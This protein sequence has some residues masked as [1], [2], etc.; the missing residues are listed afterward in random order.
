MLWVSA[1]NGGMALA[2]SRPERLHPCHIETPMID[3]D[4]RDQVQAAPATRPQSTALTV[5]AGEGPSSAPRSFAVPRADPSFVTQLIAT[6]AHVPQTC[7]LRRASPEDA[8]SSYRA[9]LDSA[10]A[11]AASASHD[12]M[13]RVV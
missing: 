7:Q 11:R 13:S 4:T 5:V 1:A 2:M 10:A 9:A 8:Q 6:A 3:P 12:G